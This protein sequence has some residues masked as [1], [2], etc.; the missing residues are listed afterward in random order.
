MTISFKK[1]PFDSFVDSLY[2]FTLQGLMNRAQDGEGEESEVVFTMK[3][4]WDAEWLETAT[5]MDP[6]LVT[7]PI[8]W[9]SF[10][11]EVRMFVFPEPNF[12]LTRAFLAIT[13]L[14]ISDH[15]I[16]F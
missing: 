5:E 15:N 11:E 10:L 2:L 13:N 3:D 16:Y 12:S 7:A 9:Y 14:K 1:Q 6:D 4:G 8:S